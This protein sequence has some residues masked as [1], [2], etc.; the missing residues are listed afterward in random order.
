MAG[1]SLDPNLDHLEARA[2]ARGLP[3]TSLRV[4]PG[5]HPR[6]R[7]DLLGDAL[8]VDGQPLRPTAIFLRHDVFAAMQDPRP[9]VAERAMAWHTLVS[10][11]ALA[12]DDVRVPNRCS[13]QY[14][15]NKPLS[16]YM[17]RRAGLRVPATALTNDVAA[18]RQGSAWPRV[19]K[20]IDGG[21]LCEP[22]EDVLARTP[23]QGGA[24]ASP[25]IVQERLEPPELR[26]YVVG[27][28]LFA[29]RVI[30]D[31]L[32]YRASSRTRVEPAAALPA[33][34]ARALLALA[35]QL[36]LDWAAADFKTDPGSGELCF[37][38]I[39]SAPMFV[40][41]DRACDGALGDALLDWLIP[42]QLPVDR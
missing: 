34:L 37:L 1:G 13:R 6:V 8:L 19:V 7:W 31:V 42:A 12:H 5:L 35:E 14:G 22:L 17:A 29:F 18:L 9:A 33:A 36:G 20:P 4:G 15:A 23:E 39:N 40:A 38:E 27:Q 10:G 30:S 25:A 28:R 2:R 3:L 16:L 21:A 11:W 41:F 26:V 32:D 24:A